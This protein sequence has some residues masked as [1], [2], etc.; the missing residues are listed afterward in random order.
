MEEQQETPR[1]YPG[2]FCHRCG[3]FEESEGRQN[4]AQYGKDSRLLPRK[5]LRSLARSS[6]GLQSPMDAL[7]VCLKPRPGSLGAG[8]QTL[9]VSA[10]TT[11]AA[12]ALTLGSKGLTFRTFTPQPHERLGALQSFLR[13]GDTLF[14]TY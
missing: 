14:L 1:K 11:V 7:T 8:V 12:L 4:T 6:S 13:E 2:Q 5:V 9:S 10:S 3:K